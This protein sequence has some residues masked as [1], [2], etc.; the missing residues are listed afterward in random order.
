MQRFFA[1]SALVAGAGLA[2]LG[3]GSKSDA[4][5]VRDAINGFYTSKD[6]KACTDTATPHFVKRIFGG[7]EQA[8][9][10][11]CRSARREA[12]AGNVKIQRVSITGNSA[13]AQ[14]SNPHRNLRLQL[15][16]T[17]GKW[18]LSEVTS[19]GEDPH[20]AINE[21]AQCLKSHGLTVQGP[22]DETFGKQPVPVVFTKTPSGNGMGILTY[23]YG[24]GNHLADDVQALLKRPSKPHVNILKTK[25]GPR[26]IVYEKPASSADK[27]A[28][29]ACLPEIENK[30]L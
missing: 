30:Q 21:V 5:R 24:E 2:L 17:A 14:A 11:A 9:L 1:A 12:D 28:S 3:C 10:G 20:Q 27:Q 13:T 22:K 18:K 23:A 16:K 8:A 26:I 6:A 15:I 19:L 7:T 25:R 29:E 4:D